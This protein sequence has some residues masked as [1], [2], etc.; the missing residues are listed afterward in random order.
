MIRDDRRSKAEKWA[1]KT[2]NKDYSHNAKLGFAVGDYVEIIDGDN[3]G[4]KGKVTDCLE[5]GIYLIA[6]SG[7]GAIKSEQGKCLK[8]IK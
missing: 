2:A 5:G 7:G 1:N 8:L 3:K 6:I 4:K